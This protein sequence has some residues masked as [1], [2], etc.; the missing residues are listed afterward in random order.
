MR[1]EFTK[2]HDRYTELLKVT[3]F[4]FTE[5]YRILLEFTGFLLVLT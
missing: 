4:F 2:V 5:F 3:T 1:R